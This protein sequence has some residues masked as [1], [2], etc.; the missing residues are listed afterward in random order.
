MSEAKRPVVAISVLHMGWV[1]TEL[2]LQMVALSH[3]GRYDVKIETPSDQPIASN[4]NA[5]CLRARKEIDADWVLMVDADA[6]LNGNPLDA[7]EFDPDIFAWPALCYKANRFHE[8][9]KDP[10]VWNMVDH[11]EY[12]NKYDDMD[13]DRY[14]ERGAIGA[15]R[16]RR[17]LRGPFRE[18]NDPRSGHRS[19]DGVGV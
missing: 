10:F 19:G 17:V 2:L 12:G 7:I 15:R 8:E 18:A 11:D 6:K 4:R 3:D 13:M 5:I 16:R 9:G 1:R 14:I